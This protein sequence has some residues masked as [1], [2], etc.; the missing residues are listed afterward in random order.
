VVTLE[1][2]PPNLTPELVKS[3][4]EPLF[5]LKSISPPPLP[6]DISVVVSPTCCMLSRINALSPVK[7]PSVLILPTVVIAPVPD[8]AP[9]KNVLPL[10]FN[11][12]SITVVVAENVSADAPLKNQV[13][14]VADCASP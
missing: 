10:I 9:S 13:P 4:L 7:S 1:L 12:V 2:A 14:V 6:N 5:V 8:K 11:C 3:I